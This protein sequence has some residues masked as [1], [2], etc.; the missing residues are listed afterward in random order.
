[1]F[2]I[3]YLTIMI[4]GITG[5]GKST[6]VNNLLFDGEIHALEVVGK[7]GT[8]EPTT[9]YQNKKDVPYLR[10]IDTRGIELADAWSVNIILDN[11]I[12]SN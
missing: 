5:T 10:L 1:M 8:L 7:I 2:K 9:P 4:I 3:K 6:L 11:M 12:T